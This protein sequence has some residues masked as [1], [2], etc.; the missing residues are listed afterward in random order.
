MS[1]VMLITVL[2]DVVPC[3]LV[4]TVYT[5]VLEKPETGGSSSEV[6]VLLPDYTASYPI[7]YIQLINIF[8][9][10]YTVSCYKTGIFLD[11]LLRTS[12]LVVA[13]HYSSSEPHICCKLVSCILIFERCFY[14]YTPQ[15][16]I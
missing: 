13:L 10:D 2:W 3:S 6:S 4:D 16:E 12:N 7:R 9:P 11:T 8:L 14:K 5:I 15:T 1:V